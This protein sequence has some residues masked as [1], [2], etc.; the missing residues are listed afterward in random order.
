MSRCRKI[1]IAASCLIASLGIGREMTPH[2]AQAQAA[3]GNGP[4]VSLATME[5]AANSTVAIRYVRMIDSRRASVS[6]ETGAVLSTVDSNGVKYILTAR[7]GVAD[8]RGIVHQDGAIE[9]TSLGGIPLGRGRIA[10]CDPQS[11]GADPDNI[12]TV[13]HDMCVLQVSEPAP[14]Y[15][16][17]EGFR[18]SRSLPP[19]PFRLCHKG[20]LSW[21]SGASGSPLF[22]PDMTLTGVLS[23]VSDAHEAPI[24]QWLTLLHRMRLERPARLALNG[25]QKSKPVTVASCGIFSPPSI[26]VLAFLG[27]RST[28]EHRDWSA[29]APDLWGSV[30]LPNMWL[31]YIMSDSADP[32]SEMPLT[33]TQ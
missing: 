16:Q 28:A 18:I 5:R 26:P 8:D 33:S 19:M 23:A 15:A 20:V 22:L 29:P 14:S 1:L 2:N 17:I 31:A 11:V 32:E 12:N 6:L 25:T 13:S 21:A 3:G 4:D 9:I 10:Y 7:H 30:S 27:M 24:G